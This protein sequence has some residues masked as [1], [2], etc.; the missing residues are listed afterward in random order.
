MDQCHCCPNPFFICSMLYT[1]FVS[2]CVSEGGAWVGEW[3]SGCV[4]EWMRDSVD[5]DFAPIAIG[6]LCVRRGCRHSPLY[7]LH[8]ST[9]TCS[10]AAAGWQRSLWGSQNV[11]MLRSASQRRTLPITSIQPSR[12]N[13]PNSWRDFSIEYCFRS[14]PLGIRWSA[15]IGRIILTLLMMGTFVAW[16]INVVWDNSELKCSE[17]ACWFK[18]CHTAAVL[19]SPFVSRNEARA[20]AAQLRIVAKLWLFGVCQHNTVETGA[21]Y[22]SPVFLCSKQIV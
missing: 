15:V 21:W 22:G 1:S 8:A 5:E 3:V 9:A 17:L 7:K 19:T 18:V 11:P 12:G 14:C 6:C 2:E 4:N 16:I 10:S 13:F 20:V